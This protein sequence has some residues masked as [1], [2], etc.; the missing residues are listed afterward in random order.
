M[1]DSKGIQRGV[2]A[3]LLATVVG[4]VAGRV[5]CG[6]FSPPSECDAGGLLAMSAI[7]AA[8]FAIGMFLALWRSP[9]S[10]FAQA[11]SSFIANWIVVALALVVFAGFG[12]VLIALILLPLL[13]LLTCASWA[14][15]RL[16]K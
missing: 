8:G 14:M 1:V 6:S 5:V 16:A 4:F 12:G 10:F 3:T 7:C 9:A 15:A 2:A 13:F 11:S